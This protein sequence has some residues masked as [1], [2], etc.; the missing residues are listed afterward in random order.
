MWE[1]WARAGY[2][3][4]LLLLRSPSAQITDCGE[5]QGFILY[6][7]KFLR[8]EL[9]FTMSPLCT[10]CCV[11]R[12]G[13]LGLWNWYK[14]GEEAPMF[15]VQEQS[16]FWLC[17]SSGSAAALRSAY[18]LPTAKK[19]V[20]PISFTGMNTRGTSVTS[21]FSNFKIIPALLK[22]SYKTIC[23]CKNELYQND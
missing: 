1:R 23:I 7:G 4:V 12:T 2:V 16:W 8:T 21:V 20:T 19:W 6:P 10:L 18:L 5:G 13:L 11:F 14:P 3:T 15:A 17:L 9:T 22:C